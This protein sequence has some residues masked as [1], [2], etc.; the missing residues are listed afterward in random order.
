MAK[1]RKILRRIRRASAFGLAIILP[2]SAAEYF[3]QRPRNPTIEARHISPTPCQQLYESPS[4]EYHN[5]SEHEPPILRVM[6]PDSPSTPSVSPP[7]SPP[8][9]QAYPDELFLGDEI[10]HETFELHISNEQEDNEPENASQAHPPRPSSRLDMR[11][12]EPQSILPPLDGLLFPEFITFRN[13]PFPIFPRRKADPIIHRQETS[14]IPAITESLEIFATQPLE[15]RLTRIPRREVETTLPTENLEIIPTPPLEQ[16]LTRIP[17]RGADTTSQTTFTP[18]AEESLRLSRLE[19][20]LDNIL[21][22][23]DLQGDGLPAL[24]TATSILYYHPP[25]GPTLHTAPLPPLALNTSGLSSGHGEGCHFWDSTA[26][27]AGYSTIE[28]PNAHRAPQQQSL[29]RRN[30]G[31][32]FTYKGRTSNFDKNYFTYRHDKR[33]RFLEQDWEEWMKQ[34]TM[35]RK[36]AQR[37]SLVLENLGDFSVDFEPCGD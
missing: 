19:E 6:N 16:R 22:A 7:P 8:S 32:P 10:T 23:L 37:L 20:T 1:L 21:A 28:N 9:H 34:L 29:V 18:F 17:R 15:Q 13:S 30:S 24:T 36:L 3:P 11:P 26:R 25:R 4:D 5:A 33:K 35:A 31:L 27:W 12:E 2:D 14:M